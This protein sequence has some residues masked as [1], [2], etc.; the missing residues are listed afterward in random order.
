MIITEKMRILAN[1]FVG[2]GSK[3]PQEALS[4]NGNIRARQIK[5]ETKHWPD[6]V[7]RKDYTLPELKEVKTYIKE[8]NHLSGVPSAKEILSKGQNLG[9]MNSVLLGKVEE[10]T[11]YLFKR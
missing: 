3:A 11:L 2:I 9:E 1:G 7:F 8:N 10:L 6:Y 4:V 5:V